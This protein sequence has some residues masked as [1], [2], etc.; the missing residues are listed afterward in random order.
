MQTKWKCVNG[1]GN[2][3]AGVVG[4][5]SYHWR[6]KY[7]SSSQSVATDRA[8]AMQASMVKTIED[9]LQKI[10]KQL[11]KKWY[12]ISFTDVISLILWNRRQ[13]NGSRGWKQEVRIADYEEIIS[14]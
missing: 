8:W 3:K 1:N 4:R 2:E 11:A 10:T 9:I 6:P 14:K 7:S 12:Y 13:E 5:D